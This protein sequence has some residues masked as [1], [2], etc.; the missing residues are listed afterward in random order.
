[1][2]NRVAR[3]NRSQFGLRFADLVGVNAQSDYVG[4]V[5]SSDT[6]SQAPRM[7]VVYLTP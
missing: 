6:A 3:Q 5:T 7:T 4:Y 2:D 1:L